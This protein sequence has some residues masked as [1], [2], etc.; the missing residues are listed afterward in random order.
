MS[1]ESKELARLHE[2]MCADALE[3]GLSLDESVACQR[4]SDRYKQ[5]NT[6]FYWEALGA[7]DLVLDGSGTA[8]PPEVREGWIAL[9]ESVGMANTS[10]ERLDQT[11]A[12]WNDDAVDVEQYAAERS[13]GN[14]TPHS[15]RTWPWVVVLLAAL[16]GAGFWL[17]PDIRNA[18][19]R[20]PSL[21]QWLGSVRPDGAERP[22]TLALTGESVGSIIWDSTQQRGRLE[23]N[24]RAMTVDS[25]RQPQVWLIDS[26]RSQRHV[27]V[28]LLSVNRVLQR[29]DLE[30]PVR[31]RQYSGVVITSEPLGG[32]LSPSET[33]I[34]AV[35]TAEPD[36]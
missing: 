22:V 16:V 3:G 17:Y 15:A 28:A 13:L 35:G 23:V 10:D 5:V 8:P 31:I 24:T 14:T 18:I 30:S 4:L 32:S 19:E 27:P 26:D 12:V 36:N 20:N 9:S 2:L 25:Q 21:Q 34:L 7:A 6:Q 29:V 33:H 1:T 11:V